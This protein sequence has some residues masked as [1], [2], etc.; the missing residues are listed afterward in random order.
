MERLQSREK[1]R[2]EGIKL[3]EEF[4][5]MLENIPETN[6]TH[7]VTDIKNVIRG[8]GK[9]ILKE[10]FREKLQR[11]APRFEEGYVVAEKGV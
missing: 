3:I 5:R 2:Q 7:Y 8:D 1:V 11:I 10:K 4:S 6:E 9:A